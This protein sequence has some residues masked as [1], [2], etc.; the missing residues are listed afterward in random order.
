MTV[1]PILASCLGRRAG[2]WPSTP[3]HFFS[4]TAASDEQLVEARAVA[5]TDI[6]DDPIPG[7]AQHSG[8]FAFSSSLTLPSESVYVIVT[9]AV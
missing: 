1:A 4:S 9:F 5:D 2:P 3:N 6:E 8:H 7:A